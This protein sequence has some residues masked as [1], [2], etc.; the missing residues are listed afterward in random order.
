MTAYNYAPS[1]SFSALGING[2]GTP[3]TT[4]SPT[5]TVNATTS[6]PTSG[7]VPPAGAVLVSVGASI[8]GSFANLTAALALLPADTSSQ[9]IFMRPESYTEQVSVNRAGPV[10]I[11]DYQSGNAGQTYT[12]NQVA[13]AFSRGLSVVAPIPSG[14]TDAETA[15][16]STATNKISFYNVNFINTDN[17]DG[18]IASFVT[19]AA[20]VY[21]DQVGIY[22]RSFTGWQDTILT[23]NPTGYAY[24]ESCYIE[25]AIDFIV[26][27]NWGSKISL[28]GTVSGAVVLETYLGSKAL[29]TL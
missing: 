2:T 26:S 19:L 10:T 15:V 11:I 16:I 12:T 17:L 14:H 1:F 18:A 20:S 25:G 13:V 22:G 21:G 5:A 24:Y 4:T 27:H 29:E 28:I 9:V 23:G 6:H 3:T 8:A 7:T